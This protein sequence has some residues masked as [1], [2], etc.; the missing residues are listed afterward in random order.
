MTKILKTIVLFLFSL[1]ILTEAQ[2]CN[3][4]ARNPAIDLYDSCRQNTYQIMGG[5]S[6]F[7]MYSG[8]YKCEWKV[9]GVTLQTNSSVI[10]HNIYSNGTY[11]ICV[12]AIDTINN[13]DTTMCTTVVVD[14]LKCTNWKG[15][16]RAFVVKDTCDTYTGKSYYRLDGV[17]GQIVMANQSD[18]SY[19]KFKWTINSKPI[20]A[21]KAFYNLLPNGQYTV[22][23]NIKDTVNDCDTTLC[24]TVNVNCLPCYGWKDRIKELLIYDSCHPNNKFILGHVEL[25]NT[26]A[27]T[28]KWSVLNYENSTYYNWNPSYLYYPGS[29]GK[30]TVSLKL[31]DTS[32][33]CDTT[34]YRTIDFQCLPACKWSEQNIQLLSWYSCNKNKD[35]YIE[36]RLSTNF[37]HISQYKYEWKLNNSTTTDKGG[38]FRYDLDSNG[39]YTIC[40]KVTDTF[41]NCDTVLCSTLNINCMAHCTWK[42]RI[43]SLTLFDSCGGPFAGIVG[44][45]NFNDS[46]TSS[47]YIINWYVNNKFADNSQIMMQSVLSNG[48]YNVCLNIEDTTENCDT[49]ICQ[50]VTVDCFVG[51]NSLDNKLQ[52]LIVYPN[53]ADNSTS[54]EWLVEGDKY[55]LTDAL[56]RVYLTG[57]TITGLNTIDTKQLSNGVYWIRITGESSNSSSKLFISR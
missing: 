53:P 10:Q 33:N 28:Y 30:Y 3:W 13:C 35:N 38:K 17:L 1:P 15:K 52:K 24:K 46:T 49:T 11:N 42:S 29:N 45:V 20:K 31:T 57:E 12:K 55:E 26:R 18:Y 25:V 27:V 36:S 23:L 21:F 7:G 6:F 9:N 4:K 14:C 37:S 2:N 32:K 16:I 47:K 56:G 54:F 19:Y 39:T 34:I 22:C 51:L 8:K 43:K 5:I 48:K 50:N 41:N 40:V 44:E